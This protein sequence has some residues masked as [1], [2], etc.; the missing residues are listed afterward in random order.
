MCKAKLNSR[1]VPMQ[2][3]DNIQEG[4]MWEGLSDQRQPTVYHR[5]AFIYGKLIIEYRTYI[6]LLTS[7]T[8]TN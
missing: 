4:N 8:T 7:N 2:V 3:T 6:K 5:M 1:I